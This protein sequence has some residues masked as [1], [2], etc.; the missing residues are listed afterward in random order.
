MTTIAKQKYENIANVLIKSVGKSSV[1]FDP[2]KYNTICFIGDYLKQSSQIIKFTKKLLQKSTAIKVIV[3]LFDMKNRDLCNDLKLE[4]VEYRQL[5][6]ITQIIQSASVFLYSTNHDT[7]LPRG[8]IYSNHDI[9]CLGFKD[10][11]SITTLHERQKDMQKNIQLQKALVRIFEDRGFACENV[12]MQSFITHWFNK[13]TQVKIQYNEKES[14]LDFRV[15]LFLKLLGS[16]KMIAEFQK[17]MSILSTCS[18]DKDI[19][20]SSNFIDVVSS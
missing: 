6:D 14:V 20:Q 2:E 16:E 15:N 19:L 10:N 5:K 4:S 17:M 8:L 12:N 13:Y 1:N 9:I 18:S 3:Y 7:S 11:E